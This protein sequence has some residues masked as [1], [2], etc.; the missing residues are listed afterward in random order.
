MLNTQHNTIHDHEIGEDH[1]MTNIST[2]L[3]EDAFD[4]SDE[5][6]IETIAE[7]FREI[8]LTLGLDLNDDNIGRAV[9]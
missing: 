7:H 6:K 2:P 8:M 4:I 5:Q 1:I 3:R 9:V